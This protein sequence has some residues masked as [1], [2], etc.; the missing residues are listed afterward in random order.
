MNAALDKLTSEKRITMRSD[1]KELVI[2]EFLSRGPGSFK[3]FA[4]DPRA[5]VSY[6]AWRQLFL[7]ILRE[8]PDFFSSSHSRFHTLAAL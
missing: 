2:G 4:Y 5:G 1:P 3:E 7:I 8:G 6:D